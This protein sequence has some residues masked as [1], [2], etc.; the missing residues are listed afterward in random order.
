[1]G[2][3]GANEEKK[4]E[5]LTRKEASERSKASLWGYGLMKTAMMSVE[6]R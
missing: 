5:N 1:V 6:K 4:K 2:K 3:G